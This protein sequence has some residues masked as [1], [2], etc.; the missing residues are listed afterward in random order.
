MRK[1]LIVDDNPDDIE[2]TKIALEESGWDLHVEACPSAEQALACLREPGDLPCS[3]F[4]DLNI[5]GMG[6]IECLR[7]I[8]ADESLKSIPVIMVTASSFDQ[9]REKAY[10]AGA[11]FFLYKELD[12]DRFAENL[13]AALKR[14][15]V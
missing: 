8:R 13:D 4:L 10:D 7:R 11:N 3:I 5:P 15:M 12:I 6:G 9:D 1:I 14:T 2:I